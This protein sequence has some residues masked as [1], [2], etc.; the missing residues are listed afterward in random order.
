[1]GDA[2]RVGV[3]M[4]RT[5]AAAPGRSARLPRHSCSQQHLASGFASPTLTL[6][7]LVARCGV[8]MMEGMR[9]VSLRTPPAPYPWALVTSLHLQRM[10]HGGV[11]RGDLSQLS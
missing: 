11:G 6:A 10:W 5:S 4:P 3:S 8:H 7:L 1:M 9:V 2:T